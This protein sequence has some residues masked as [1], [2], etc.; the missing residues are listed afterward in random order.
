MLLTLVSRVGGSFVDL[1]RVLSPLSSASSSGNW[2]SHMSAGGML[3]Y[4]MP[5]HAP[6]SYSYST[7]PYS[8]SAHNRWEKKQLGLSSL[9]NK[10]LPDPPYPQS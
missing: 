3:E 2:H 5:M 9:S 7:A 10:P 1:Y 6:Q 8:H 4:D